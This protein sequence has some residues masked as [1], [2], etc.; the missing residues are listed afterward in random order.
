MNSNFIVA[1]KTIDGIPLERV[2]PIL[3]PKTNSYWQFNY[4]G[5]YVTN[6]KTVFIANQYCIYIRDLGVIYISKDSQ[7]KYSICKCNPTD[8]EKILKN[9][10]F[11]DYD[12][13]Y[14]LTN[15]YGGNELK[16]VLK[17]L[18]YNISSSDI[19]VLSREYFLEKIYPNQ[20]EYL[21][22]IHS[23]SAWKLFGY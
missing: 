20:M 8:Y 3:N 19:F 14:P 2:N 7:T 6:G 15:L 18:G 16:E 10:T 22:K 5:R 13:I 23:Y 4:I 17:Q 21:D 9:A 11:L 1:E 12:K